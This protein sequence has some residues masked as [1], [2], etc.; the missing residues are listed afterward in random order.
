MSTQ[1]PNGLITRSTTIVGRMG[2]DGKVYR[3]PGHFD[4]MQ[5]ASWVDQFSDEDLRKMSHAL[6]FDRPITREDMVAFRR[7]RAL[8]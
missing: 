8:A 4:S 2:A 1:P 6:D 7:R 3:R 5:T